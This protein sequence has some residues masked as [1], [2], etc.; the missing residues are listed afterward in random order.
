ML[1][2]QTARE[3]ALSDMAAARYASMPALG[4]IDRLLA[5]GTPPPAVL[6]GLRHILGEQLGI[7]TPPGPAGVA[8]MIRWLL[9]LRPGPFTPL[10][11]ALAG[12]PARIETIPG[13]GRER[14]LTAAEA[15]RLR[16]PGRTRLTGWERSGLMIAGTTICAEVRLL[17]APRLLGD[18]EALALI[19]KGQPC[20]TVLPGLIRA[21]TRAVL[22]WPGDPAVTGHADL[23]TAAG[24]PFGQAAERVTA[25]LCRRVAELAP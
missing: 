10:A 25:A 15:S 14:R 23:L 17:I 19:R 21:Q 6:S 2:S 7:T 24:R 16:L 20:G 18:D 12:E 1:P 5:S 4:D 11:A 9:R 13:S 3:L 22:A 8:D